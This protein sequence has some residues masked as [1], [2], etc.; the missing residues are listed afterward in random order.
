[1]DHSFNEN[2]M[3]IARQARG[4]SQTELSRR[5]GVSQGYVSKLEN[6]MDEPNAG[7]VDKLSSVLRFPITYFYEQDH[8]SGLPVSVHSMY[9]KRASVGQRAQDRLEAEINIRLMHVRRLLK[10]VDFDTELDLPSFELD[11]F[12][13]GP[14][15]IA[16]LL[17]RTWLVPSGP[18]RNLIGWMERAG[19]IVI[20]SDF[21]GLSVD[22]VTVR[23]SGLP[24][25]VFLNRGQPADR[26]RFTLAHELGHIIMHRLPSPEME[27]EANAFASALLMPALDIKRAFSG[28]VTIQKLAS[29][30]PVWRVSMNALLNRAKT[31]GSVTPNQAQYLWR[32]MSALGYRRA[33]PP[34]LAFPSEEASILSELVRVHLEDL[35]YGIDDLCSLLHVYDED[36]RRIHPL[37][38]S[39]T[40]QHLRIVK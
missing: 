33:E 8:V 4:W 40:G 10:S 28:K 38:K 25:C 20:P 14:E 31:I 19:I 27:D 15:Q 1:M 17:R 26:Q 6:G 11:E 37:P 12:E 2:L 36:F 3:R 29:L 35:E 22:G 16:D 7:I 21:D 32:Q 18:L 39:S 9:R 34:E 13:T 5:S 24:P 30:K 23:Q